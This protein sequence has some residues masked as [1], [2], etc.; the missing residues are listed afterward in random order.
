[1]SFLQKK[2]LITLIVLFAFFILPKESSA[3]TTGIYVFVDGQQMEFTNDPFL[4]KG[5]TLIEFRPIFESLGMAVQWDSKKQKVTGTKKGLTIEMTLN[6]RT[7]L[8]NGKRI[9][10]PLAPTVKNGRTLIPLRFVSEVSGKAVH[11]NGHAKMIIVNDGKPFENFDKTAP[12]L[13]KNILN[14]A[15]NGRIGNIH[16]DKFRYTTMA[17]FVDRF[18]FPDY[19]YDGTPHSGDIPYL[20]YG[21]YV[22]QTIIH[23]GYDRLKP[24]MMSDRLSI[25]IPGNKTVRD[26]VNM[27]GS[28]DEIDDGM[29]FSLIYHS[30]KYELVFVVDDFYYDSPVYSYTL[31]KRW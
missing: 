13:N 29:G 27:I 7:A 31:Y 11:W 16:M 9:Q 20:V 4:T 25:F 26:I 30:G 17:Q 6:N 18:G 14:G 2:L 22:F 15:Y 23:D 12:P 5:T 10:M 8:V 19:R 3:K 21:D 24:M 1:M 28:P